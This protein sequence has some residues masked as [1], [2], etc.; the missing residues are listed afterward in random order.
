MGNLNIDEIY[1]S[2][3]EKLKGKDLIGLD[4]TTLTVKE[5]ERVNFKDGA[6]K[7]VLHFV[8]IEKS[9]I[10]NATN[11]RRLAKLISPDASEWIGKQITIAHALTEFKGEMVDT[12]EVQVPH[13]KTGKTLVSSAPTPRT[14]SENPAPDEEPF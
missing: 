9:M 3:G 8:E 2:F 10:V 12:I 13:V 7:L 11:A 5:V 1:S 14:E 4:P 6:P